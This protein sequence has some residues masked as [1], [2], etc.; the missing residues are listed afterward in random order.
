MSSAAI[1]SSSPSATTTVYLDAPAPDSDDCPAGNFSIGLTS[2]ADV[3]ACECVKSSAYSAAWTCASSGVVNVQI[4]PIGATQ[5]G[6]E[7]LNVSFLES[8]V[9]LP[10]FAYGA[11]PPVLPGSFT[12]RPF[13]DKNNGVPSL[14]FW[15]YYEKVAI[16]KFVCL[17]FYRC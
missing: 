9:L 16:C 12:L 11:Q 13:G 3:N 2:D 4:T 17:W 5:D 7:M 10:G 6:H 8:A 15:D 14:V 1:A